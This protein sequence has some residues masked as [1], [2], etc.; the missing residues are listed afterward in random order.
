[1]KTKMFC[2][3]GSV[4]LS[5]TRDYKGHV[6]TCNECGKTISIPLESLPAAGAIYGIL[7]ETAQKIHDELA[8]VQWNAQQEKSE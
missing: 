4:D 7:I 3:C 5:V 1:M 2:S 6:I 8:A